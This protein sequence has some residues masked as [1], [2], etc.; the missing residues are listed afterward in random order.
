MTGFV[1]LL[2]PKTILSGLSLLLTVA[3][4]FVDGMKDDVSLEE[5]LEK[6]YGITKPNKE[7][8]DE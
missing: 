3:S 8:S 4:F 5:T 7:E 6:E 2:K 1:K